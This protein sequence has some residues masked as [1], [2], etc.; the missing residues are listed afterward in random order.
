MGP[1]NY[2]VK[3]AHVR[4]CTDSGLVKFQRKTLT[5]TA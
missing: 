3:I 2:G 5:K 4:S 1:E